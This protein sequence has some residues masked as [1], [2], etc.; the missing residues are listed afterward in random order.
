MAE[1]VEHLR[2]GFCGWDIPGLLL[3]IAAVAF[4]VIR[5]RSLKQELNKLEEGN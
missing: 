1:F 3:I 4:V 5:K 2:L